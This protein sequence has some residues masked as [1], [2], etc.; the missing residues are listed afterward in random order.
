[1]TSHLLSVLPLL[2]AASFGT[3]GA[4]SLLGPQVPRAGLTPGERAMLGAC[5]D[6]WLATQRAG[7]TDAPSA[8]TAAERAVLRAADE[9]GDSLRDL[10]AGT[11]DKD[12]LLYMLIGAAV[13]VALILVF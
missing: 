5:R 9:R 10:R 4:G 13:V 8:L 7:A 12:A 1:M 11:S 2:L 6:P 3:G